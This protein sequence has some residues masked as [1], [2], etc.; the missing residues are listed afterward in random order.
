M[1]RRGGVTY[2]TVNSV[3][4]DMKGQATYRIVGAERAAVVGQDGVHGYRESPRPATLELTISDR[5]DLD[6]KALALVSDATLQLQ[7]ANGKVVTFRN[8]W[9]TGDW[10]ASTEEGE[11]RAMF[12]AVSASETV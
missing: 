6:L 9:A 3:G 4:Y 10:E 8:A 5:G 11:V 7:L 2:F 12:E 1:Q